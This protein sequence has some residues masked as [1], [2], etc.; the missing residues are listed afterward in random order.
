MTVFYDNAVDGD[1]KITKTGAPT[2]KNDLELSKLP[3]FL[4]FII[5]IS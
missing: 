4:S 5:E 2:I 3:E 1:I